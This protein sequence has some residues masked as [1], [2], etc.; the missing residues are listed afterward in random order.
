MN[1]NKINNIVGCQRS[2][3]L[4]NDLRDAL[5]DQE[6]SENVLVRSHGLV[7]HRAAEL[8]E[9]NLVRV[10]ELVK[11]PARRLRRVNECHAD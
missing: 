4:G 1:F 9:L 5:G 7:L 11:S 10:P 3:E 2:I 6:V 8:R